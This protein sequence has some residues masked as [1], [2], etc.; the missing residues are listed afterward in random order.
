T[1][2]WI[3]DHQA[4]VEAAAVDLNEQAFTHSMGRAPTERE[5]E[6]L[7]E[8][9]NKWMDRSELVADIGLALGPAGVLSKAKTFKAA[10]ALG[11]GEGALSTYLLA[12]SEA[13]TA[14]ER[15]RDRVGNAAV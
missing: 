15:L 12:D 11:A 6:D 4:S 1:A 10:L 9:T 14:S 13:E 3:R 2:Q 8:S 5:K 7:R